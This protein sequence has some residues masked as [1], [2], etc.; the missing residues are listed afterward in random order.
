MS[1]SLLARSLA[2]GGGRRDRHTGLLAVLA[3]GI[4]VAVLLLTLGANVALLERSDRTAWTRPVAAANPVAVQATSTAYLAGQP[5][6]VVRLAATSTGATPAPPGLSAFPSPGSVWL[7]PALAADLADRPEANPFGPATGRLGGAGLTGPDQRVAVLGVRAGDPS[8]RTPVWQNQLAEADFSGAVP[9]RD[10]TGRPAASSDALRQYLTLGQIAAVLIVVPILT[11]LGAAARLGAGRRAQRLARLR[12]AGGSR[13]TVLG[14]A[15]VEAVTLGVTGSAL[16]ALLYAA[17]TPAVA[18]LPVGGSSFFAGQLWVGVVPLVAVLLGATAL[19]AV[20]MVLPLRRVLADP[21]GVT[22]QQRDRMPVWWRL[23]A[24]IAAFAG[25]ALVTRRNGTESMAVIFGLAAVFAV[26][27][28]LGPVVVHL[29]GSITVRRAK[30]RADAARLIAGR[31]LLDDPRSSFRAVSGVVMASFIAGFFALF[32]IGSG[33]TVWGSADRLEVAVPA[34]TAQ[35]DL[36]RASAALRSAGLPAT[37]HEVDAGSLLFVDQARG[38]TAYLATTLPADRKAANRVRATLAAALPGA[39]AATGSDV[40]DREDRF[41]RDFTRATAVVL[42]VGLL[43]A[44]ASAGITAAAGVLDRRET[45]RRLWHA[46]VPVRVLDR[47]RVLEHTAPLVGCAGL[48]ALAG[49]FAAAPVTA[50]QSSIGFGGIAL[51]TGALAGGYLASRIALAASR[52]LLANA[53][54]H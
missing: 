53:A 23:L 10:F 49:I 20:S 19:F 14:V 7:S 15:A 44:A 38:D 13:R 41:A 32:A 6:T 39:P 9:I 40:G 47:S 11:L 48:A 31:R 54:T 35:H 25:F 34:A 12:L 51:L 16:G 17:A 45:Y 37:L 52:R 21:L 29:L 2:R 27:A 43:V 36:Q 26:I 22:E 4:G 50:Q 8:L 46:G 3:V 1:A 28:A 18:H 33:G 24:G 5:V 30:R 42:I